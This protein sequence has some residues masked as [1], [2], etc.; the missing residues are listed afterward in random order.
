MFMEHFL[1]KN[2]AI[3]GGVSEQALLRIVRIGNAIDLPRHSNG[4]LSGIERRLDDVVDCS[5]AALDAQSR[6]HDGEGEFSRR[7]PAAEYTKNVLQSGRQL[8]IG[9]AFLDGHTQFSW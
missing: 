3:G 6:A 7:A 2:T 1:Q 4:D 9:H 5:P 8:L